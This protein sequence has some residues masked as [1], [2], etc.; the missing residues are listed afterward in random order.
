VAALP[1]CAPSA[2]GTPTGVS[3]I[4]FTADD[5]QGGTC[6]GSVK[7]CVPHDKKDDVCTD[8]G[9]LY[10]STDICE[11]GHQLLAE[12]ELDLEI[13]EVTG[14]QAEISFSV[15]DDSHVEIAVFDISGRRVAT[16]ENA[17]LSSGVYDRVWKMDGVARGL[18]FVRMHAGEVTVTQRVLKLQ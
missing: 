1:R 10:V 8:D 9:Q 5:G 14:S 2:T 12:D 17:Q 6:D 4:R 11:K 18:Y 15:P 16:I 3:T 13:N 7:V